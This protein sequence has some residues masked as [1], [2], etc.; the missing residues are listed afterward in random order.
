MWVQ[1]A[2]RW[3]TGWVITAT[4]RC[5]FPISR[6][7]EHGFFFLGIAR[8]SIVDQIVES[9]GFCNQALERSRLVLNYTAHLL[10]LFARVRAIST[11]NSAVKSTYDHRLRKTWYPVRSA[12]IKPQIDRLVVGW[13]TTSESRL[14]YVFLLFLI[15]S[16]LRWREKV[17]FDEAK[18]QIYAIKFFLIWWSSSVRRRYAPGAK[19]VASHCIRL[20]CSSYADRI[21]YPLSSTLVWP[22]LH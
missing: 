4:L 21:T 13:V 14:L 18:P 20:F 9:R 6:W 3:S 7:Q 17:E 12:L 19:L 16:S 11:K 15:F 5:Y 2:T 22:P 1:R 8:S 10:A